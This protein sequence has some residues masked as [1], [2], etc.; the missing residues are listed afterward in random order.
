MPV[1]YSI[2]FL[3][4]LIAILSLSVLQKADAADWYNSDWTYARKITIN[5]GQV[6]ADLRNFPVLIDTNGLSNADPYSDQFVFVNYYNTTK[7]DH[8]I[9][10][11]ADA[12]NR[13]WAWV[14]VP[15]VFNA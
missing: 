2:L 3:V 10:K 7:F 9:E 4:S 5:N 1:R 12:Q 8:E 13:L 14:E 11:W 15:T 6:D